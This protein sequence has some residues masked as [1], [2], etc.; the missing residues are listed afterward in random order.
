[1]CHRH[2]NRGM[3][4]IV[5]DVWQLCHR[6]FSCDIDDMNICHQ[7]CVTSNDSNTGDTLNASITSMTRYQCQH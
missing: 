2:E 7:A 3:C 6:C 5:C 4:D 1:M